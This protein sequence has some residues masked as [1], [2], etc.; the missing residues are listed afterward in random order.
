MLVVVTFKTRLQSQ[1]QS[2]G[3][4]ILIPKLQTPASLE[5][6]LIL[7]KTEGKRRRGETAE[8]REARHAVVQGV[9]KS[10]TRLSNWTT[11][12]K[13]LPSQKHHLKRKQDKRPAKW[14]TAALPPPAGEETNIPTDAKK[15][16]G[17]NYKWPCDTASIGK[18]NPWQ[19]RKLRLM[20][21]RKHGLWSHTLKDMITLRLSQ[22]PN[23]RNCICS[24]GD[25]CKVR[26]QVQRWLQ[27]KTCASH[28][29]ARVCN[30][31]SVQ[32]W[33]G[34]YLSV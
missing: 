31:L 20:P 22:H 18:R 29:H 19:N 8:D 26:L 16:L 34:I 32:L 4:C 33:S 6:T 7:G 11:T 23:A 9:T 3:I 15:K 28:M 1:E 27:N 25:K 2:W 13:L 17:D 10:W 12:T 24:F 14:L 21:A 5:K 30:G